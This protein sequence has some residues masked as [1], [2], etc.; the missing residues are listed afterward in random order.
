MSSTAS[1]TE[2]L[3]GVADGNESDINSQVEAQ[4]DKSEELDNET[5]QENIIFAGTLL[6]EC[7][8]KLPL[9]ALENVIHMLRQVLQQCPNTHPLHSDVSYDLGFALGI[10]YMHT[11][12]TKC[13]MESMRLL[14]TGAT[15]D[16]SSTIV[17]VSST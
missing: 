17:S 4:L 7:K 8:L 2:N 13:C 12:N 1:A 16:S 10:K 5:V 6:A 14:C 15:K 3:S 9:R 11:G